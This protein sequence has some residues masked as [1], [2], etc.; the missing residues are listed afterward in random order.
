[1]LDREAQR[2]AGTHTQAA[3]DGGARRVF[4]EHR[5]HVLD[6]AIRL[7]FR[8]IRRGSASRMS[9]RVEQNDVIPLLQH[10]CLGTKVS[11]AATE[12]MHQKNCR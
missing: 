1:M 5:Q 8:W 10:P 12:P 3:N 2:D 7:E 11:R 9:T 6:E 4:S